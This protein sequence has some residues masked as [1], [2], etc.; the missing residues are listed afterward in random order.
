MQILKEMR[1]QNLHLLSL[2]SKSTTDR[3]VGDNYNH[4][5]TV[6]PRRQNKAMINYLTTGSTAVRV[7]N[8]PL[9]RPN[10]PTEL[11]H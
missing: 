8:C 6:A 4:S 3:N 2:N 5:G 10:T 11:P 9:S 1:V 7:R